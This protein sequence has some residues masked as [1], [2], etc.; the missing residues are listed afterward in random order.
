MGRPN[1]EVSITEA[2]VPNIGARGRTRRF[3]R[4]AFFAVTTGAAFAVL[5]SRHAP[6]P[7]FL[8][9]APFAAIASLYFYQAKEKT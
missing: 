3:L 8:M 9:I 1:Q 5:T 7:M 6:T 2:C 4:G